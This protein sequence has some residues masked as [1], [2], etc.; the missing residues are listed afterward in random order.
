VEARLLKVENEWRASGVNH[1]LGD[2]ASV[3]ESGK[4]PVGKPVNPEKS[5]GDSIGYDV[6]HEVEDVVDLSSSSD[7]SESRVRARSV[8]SSAVTRTKVSVPT[9]SKGTLM[10]DHVD[11]FDLF[12]ARAKVPK[13]YHELYFVD[14]FSKCPEYGDIF[15]GMRMDEKETSFEELVLKFVEQM[16]RLDLSKVLARRV[17]ISQMRNEP[18]K[19]FALRFK[20]FVRLYR[21]F[22]NLSDLNA[23]H[24]FL[25][26]LR[27]SEEVK[28]SLSNIKN[29]L[30]I[31]MVLEKAELIS[32][33]RSGNEA[34]GIG[35]GVNVVKKGKSAFGKF[36]NKGNDRHTRKCFICS[37]EDHLATDCPKKGSFQ[38]KRDISR[39]EEQVKK[40][41]KPGSGS[42][43]NSDERKLRFEINAI[44]I[45]PA[46]LCY[47]EVKVGDLVGMALVDSGS[48]VS[49]VSGSFFKQMHDYR[50]ESSQFSFGGIGSTRIM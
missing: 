18:V 3:G 27:N 33:R 48:Q 28:L 49:F 46:E 20:R 2:E 8:A 9:Y 45:K 50:L 15:D 21:R 24:M 31:A 17:R 41:H 23:A 36:K 26:K 6:N 10:A 42:G 7:E 37:S 25:N 44:S 43:G 34:N 40:A 1:L 38:D 11:R 14:S 32:K 29:T 12:V 22:D 5:G 47:V 35:H 19:D 39:K 13:E 4:T 16:D 30:T